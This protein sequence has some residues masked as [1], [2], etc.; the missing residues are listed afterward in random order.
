MQGYP[1]AYLRCPLIFF[2][3]DRKHEPGVEI[4]ADDVIL[5]GRRAVRLFLDSPTLRRWAI[6]LGFFSTYIQISPS[7]ITIILRNKDDHT[8]DGIHYDICGNQRPGP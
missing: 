3:S 5:S 1:L 8:P 7:L 4:T 2:S 6:R